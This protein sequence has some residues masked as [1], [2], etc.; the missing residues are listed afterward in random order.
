MLALR[1]PPSASARL[2]RKSRSGASLM[3]S[4]PSISPT[5]RC[6]T[7]SLLR[8]YVRSCP[9][10]KYRDCASHPTMGPENSP[11]GGYSSRGGHNKSYNEGNPRAS[12]RP[13]RDRWNSKPTHADQTGTQAPGQG[14]PDRA[15]RNNRSADRR[16]TQGSGLAVMS[17]EAMPLQSSHGPNSTSHAGFGGNVNNPNLP[18]VFPPFPGVMDANG[19]VVS[20]QPFPMPTI[21][22]QQ[23]FFTSN[24][25]AQQSV[26]RH[27][28]PDQSQQQ[29]TPQ[30]A[31]SPYPSFGLPTW[32]DFTKFASQLPPMPPPPMLNMGMSNPLLAMQMFGSI[33][34]GPDTPQDAVSNQQERYVPDERGSRSPKPVKPVIPP[35]PTADYLEQSSL[36]P[37]RNPSP[38]PLLVILDLNG[39]LVHR[40]N[41][42]SPPSYSERAG[43]RLFLDTLLSNYTVMVWSSS[44]PFTVKSLCAKLFSRADRKRLVAEWG[45]DKFNLTAHQYRN[46]VQVY[47]T[48]STVWQSSLIQ[49]SYP[50]SYRKRGQQAQEGGKKLQWDQTNTILID[51]SKLKAIAE[52][53]NILEIPEFT[54]NCS[55]EDAQVFPNVLRLLQE[56]AKYDDVSKVLHIW[57]SKL[58]ETEG[59]SVFDI[60]IGVDESDSIPAGTAAVTLG[61]H[62]QQPSIPHGPSTIEELAQA[63]TARRKARKQEKK[64]ARRL[65][66]STAPAKPAGAAFPARDRSRSPFRPARAAFPARDS[67]RS[68]LRPADAAFPARDSSRSPF[69]PARA[70]FPARG[71]SRS[72]SRPADAAFPARDSSR[73]PFR[74]AGAVFP[75]RERSRSP[76]KKLPFRQ[77]RSPARI[78]DT[79]P[80]QP[81]AGS[82]NPPQF[83]DKKSQARRDRRR[84]RKM[85]AKAARQG[86]GRRTSENYLLDQ[87]EASLNR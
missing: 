86:K 28:A 77:S 70:A 8:S 5:L 57:G 33:A 11:G 1:L 29:F 65:A 3:I 72:P 34:Y 67:S 81:R 43:L 78:R 80:Y 51:D 12:W 55:A 61:Q 30:L 44:Q 64:A 7:S 27:N 76:P 87:L 32:D 71:S 84:A 35:S 63:R 9:L 17:H 2:D 53:Y 52:P 45:R 38:Q 68:P 83:Q 24:M 19:N 36:P 75:T 10:C 49:S 69:R 54:G 48:L 58:T 4:R 15:R 82:P 56:L 59:A 46:K 85:E 21:P 47:K 25:S 16:P 73:S 62:E 41:R 6:R 22:D 66:T 39:T 23:P 18:F 60:D 79:T 13:Y 20:Q 26:F 40:K 14:L 37:K 31:P 74:S 50:R 42:N